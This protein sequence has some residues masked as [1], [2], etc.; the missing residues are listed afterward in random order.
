MITNYYHSFEYML[1]VETYLDISP[2]RGIGLFAKSD[3]PAGTKYW[4]RN[5]I[6]DKTFSIQELERLEKIASEYF[7][8]YGFLEASGNWYLCGDNARFS[9]HSPVANTINYFDEKGIVQ[10]SDILKTIRAGQE[11]FID[12]T[13]ICETCKNGVNFTEAIIL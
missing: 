4:T 12:Y 7:M 10:Y 11:I 9:N 13:Q 1:L 3:L 8:K 5:E 6:F 2:G